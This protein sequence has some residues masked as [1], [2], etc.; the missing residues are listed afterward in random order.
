MAMVGGWMLACGSG[1]VDDGGD[2]AQ[3]EAPAEKEPAPEPSTGGKGK[4]LG[5]EQGDV[6][7]YV[8]LQTKEGERSLHG[9][10]ELCPG[11][12]S[13]ASALIGKKVAFTT[14]WTTVQADSCEGNPDCTDT[15]KVE[16]VTGLKAA[17]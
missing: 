17:K 7:C 9:D 3:P 13:D 2:A 14:G 8:D 5:L 12:G 15:Q 1:E 16:L 10:F 11:G 4:L 6:A